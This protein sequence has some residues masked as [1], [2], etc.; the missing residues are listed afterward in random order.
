MLHN[1]H[2]LCLYYLETYGKRYKLSLQGA[3]KLDIYY[4]FIPSYENYV[5][6]TSKIVIHAKCANVYIMS[7]I[8]L[9]LAY[10]MFLIIEAAKT[11]FNFVVYIVRAMD[12]LP[13]L[14]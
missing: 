13:S 14:W 4:V 12:Q 11:T 6:Q 10:I 3:F 9:V 7:K 8:I 5:V 1:Y 2:S